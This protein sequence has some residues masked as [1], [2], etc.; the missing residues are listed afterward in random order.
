METNEAPKKKSFFKNFWKRSRHYSL[1]NQQ[2]RSTR[3]ANRQRTI[4]ENHHSINNH[5]NHNNQQQHEDNCNNINNN[6]ALT[7]N[8]CCCIVQ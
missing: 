2:P 3:V 4:E 1:E 8:P 6:P 5:N 7:S